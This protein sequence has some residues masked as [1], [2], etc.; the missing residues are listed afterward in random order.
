MTESPTQP[1]PQDQQSPVPAITLPKGGGAIRGIGEKF[2][3]NPVTG[4]GSITVPIASSPGRGG[5]GPQL[6]L[7]Y[8]S[9]SGN[10]P[11]GFGWSLGL[12]TITRK[13]DQG[14]P[15][16]HDGAESDVFLLSGAE[17]LVQVPGK[18]GKLDDCTTAPGY[19]IRRYRP[20]IEG[21]F[22]RVERWTSTTHREDV[23]WR[24][25]SRDNLLTLYGKDC[26]ARIYDP[27][28]PGRIFSW[29][30]CETRDTKGN[31]IIYCYKAEDGAQAELTSPP[32]RNRGGPKDPRRAVNRYI[33]WIRYA[34]RVPL[35]DAAG[36]R[37]RFLTEDQL[38]HA[39]WCFEVVFDYGEHDQDVPSRDEKKEQTWP[40]RLDPFSTY[41]PG[42]EVRT[43]RLCRRVLMFHHFPA[44]P[45]VGRDCLVRSTDFGYATSPVAS[46]LKSVTQRGYRR[47]V[48]DYI[49]GSM[50]AVEFGYS[51][52]IIDD[53]IHNVDAG[54]LENLPAGIDDAAYRL[55][56]LDSEGLEGVLTDAGG[57]WR[58]KPNLGG[59][60]LGP[61]RLTG[62]QPSTAALGGGQQLRDLAGDGRLDLV[63]FSGPT[64]GFF[65]R[66]DGTWDL[67]RPFRSLPQ[68]AW[69]D[70]RLRTVDLT[71]DGL[72]D[73]LLAED[74]VFTWY[75]SLG[76]DGF[77][78][79]RR[80]HQLRDEEQGPRLVDADGI[81][82]IY[83]ADMS[84]DG[85]NDL[86]RIRNGEV[87]Y[88]PSLGYGH[89]G[90]KITMA[91]A[92]VFDQPDQFS[93]RRLRVADIDGSG[94]TDL[95][96]LGQDG[97]RLYFNQ[98][99]NG[100]SNARRL[101]QFPPIDDLATVTTAD[102]LGNGTA[103]LI[104]SSPLPQHQG[105]Q[106]RYIDL[107]GGRKPHLL[108]KTSNN[109]GAETRVDY[110]P[111]TTF[112]LHDKA[113]GRPWVTRLPFPVHVVERV[114]TCDQIGRNRFVT[115]YAYHHGFF[116]G[117]EREFRGFAMV[118]QWDTET[119]AALSQ[120]DSFPVGDNIDADSHVPP[121]HTKTWFHTGVYLGRGNIS[122]FFAGL[123]D[124]QDPGEYY[125]EPAW[126][127]DDDAA[128]K[129]LLDDTILP[130]GLTLEEE[131][132]ACRALKGS[133]LR[134]EIYAEDGTDK[135]NH[136]Y[137]VT[138]Q[139]L[140]VRM[141][142]PHRD[143]NH[144]AVFFAHP[145]EAINYHYERNP[146]D[147]RILHT[148]TLEVDPFGNVLKEAAV[149]YGRP[150]T[151]ASLPLEAGG[152]KQI[153]PLITYTE[154]R[155][156]DPV[157][158]KDNHHMPLPA[159]TRTYELTGYA[160]TGI[161][162][163]AKDFVRP[164]PHN[165]A[166]LIH[167]F[168]QELKYEAQATK[169]RQ[170]RLIE[171]VRIL[172]RRNNLTG[173]LGLGELESLAL[174]GES[175]KLAFTAGLIKKVFRRPHDGRPHDRR[176]PED[177]IPN[178]AALLGSEGGYV[179]LDGD[180][181]WWI[182]RGRVFH[183]PNTTDTAPQELA[184]A[185]KHFFLT[186]RYRDPFGHR[187][188][189][190]FDSHDLLLLEARDPLGNRITVAERKPNGDIDPTKLGNDYRVLQPWFVMD[191][192]RN[193]TQVAFDALG[194]VVGVA[195]MGK[196]EENLGDSLA[197]FQAD[198]PEPV[199]LDH[200]ATPLQNPQAILQQAS[201]RLVYDLL[202]Y[203][204]T[205][206]QPNPR[207]A[208]AYTM[209]RETHYAE[210][211]GQ[212]SRVQHAFSYSDGFG[213]EI[214]KRIQAEPGPVPRRD[215]MGVIIFGADGQPEMTANDVNPR[216]VGSGWTIFN[217]KGK[218][219]RQYEPFFSEMHRFEFAL[220][221]GVSPVLFYDP[222]GRV[223]ATLHPNH[224]WEKAVFGPW[225]QEMWDVN[226]TVAL[227]A[228]QDDQMRP[229]LVRPDGSP[230][231]PPAD[232]TPSWLAVRTDPGYV[233]EA[234]RRWPDSG[235][236]AAEKRAGER[237]VVHAGTPTVAYMDVL[238][239]AF[240]TVSHNK[241]RYSDTGATDPPVEEF[242]STQVALDI[243]GN[244]G[245]VIDALGR[246]VVRHDYD[247]LGNLIHRAEMDSGERWMLD[248]VAGNALYRWD[249][250]DQRFRT[251]YDPLGR[252]TE[253]FLRIG[254]SAELLVMRQVYGEAKVNAEAANLRGQVVQLFDQAGIVTNDSY[255]FKGN[256]LSSRRQI[257]QAYKTTVDWSRT[258]P[259]EP[260]TFVNRTSYDALNRP[261]QLIAPHSDRPGSTINVVQLIHNE[262][263]LLDK[264]HAWLNQT[265]EPTDSLDPA[266]AD[267]HVVTDISYDARGRRIRV[268]YGTGVTT[269]YTYDSLSFR[270]VHLLT[271]RP[272]GAFPDDCPK[273]VLSGWPGC[274]IQNLHYAYDPIG[275]V[276]SIRDDAQQA[277][278]FRNK[279]VEP[280]GE[281]VYDALYRLIEA[282]GREH[283]G[284]AGSG[285]IPHTYNDARR[286]GLPAADA[287]GR[288]SPRDGK[289]MGTY[290][291]RYL[292]D[293]VGNLMEMR[294]RGSDPVHAGWS[295]TYTYAEISLIECG[296]G[297]DGSQS[298]IGNRL[299]YTSVAN[300]SIEPYEYDA[301]GNM[302]SMPQLQEM[303]WDYRDQLRMTR[304]QKVGGADFDGIQR[305][306]ERTYYV[307][308]AA[309]QRIRTVTERANGARKSERISL[310]GFDVFR[311][312]AGPRAGLVRETLH[313][314]ADAQRV[315]LIET[316][317]DV[318]DGGPKQLVRYQ[319]GNHLG[320]VSMELDDRARLI[321]YEEYAPYG[322][323]MFQAV[324]KQAETPKRFRYGGK[325][326]DPETG[327]YYHG[328]RFYAPWLGRWTS[329]DPA[330]TDGVSN[331]YGYGAS[332]PLRF[333]DPTGSS[334]QD[335]V[336][337][338]CGCSTS[339][340][341][342]FFNVRKSEFDLFPKSDAWR[343]AYERCDWGSAIR[344]SNAAKS[345]Q[346][347]IA[348]SP[349]ATKVVG[350]VLGV[351]SVV[352][353]NAPNSS[354]L[355]S[356]MQEYYAMFRF[357]STYA[358]AIVGGMGMLR[359][360]SSI[361]RPPGPP[362]APP[363][364][365]AV[366]SSGVGSS[367]VSGIAATNT[368]I[369]INLMSMMSGGNT[370]DE[371]DP[372]PLIDQEYPGASGP[373]SVDPLGE[374]FADP[375]TK[376]SSF[377]HPSQ[378]VGDHILS[379][380]IARFR[381]LNA[382][383]GK[384]LNVKTWEANA[385]KAGFEGNYLK[386]L[387]KYLRQ[388]L[389]DEEAVSVLKGELNYITKEVHAPPV[390][391]RTLHDLPS[392]RVSDSDLVCR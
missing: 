182:P 118:E 331:S 193:R 68:I 232:Y 111:S 258:V 28:D 281:Y 319:L 204:R 219:V 303:A 265:A 211:G 99:G 20:R 264:V 112:Y 167:A 88:W 287:V 230:R 273:P 153:S 180:G 184:Y 31:A 45:G 203:Q 245:D 275:N 198:L 36:Q 360:I 131:R 135:A 119:F 298:I 375:S 339:I 205:K 192:N 40:C 100:W 187:S 257:A 121:V 381:E 26:T 341:D 11:F 280:S 27:A 50:P 201:T 317:N 43:Y 218:P 382:S 157:A 312:Y 30:I 294:H 197:G 260:E 9:G 151:D 254:S 241:F 126:R 63:S 178:P 120:S 300:G 310:N 227:D 137:T 240:F 51:Q 134:Q 228:T 350:G 225:S 160:P 91:N 85:L 354:E 41:R 59:G 115:R 95:I 371:E 306:G 168:D 214:Q 19:A 377:V 291:E 380:A 78:E 57:A 24:S 282:D 256:L 388:G 338:F 307:Y 269:S 358:T 384:N 1:Q 301:H 235:T 315:A 79:A 272:A 146:T 243:E 140:T 105:R 239:R 326:R 117:V 261:I 15:Q 71:G 90:A 93:Q 356:A 285:P 148:L 246:V 318:D 66:T 366:E 22:A 296:A 32:E 136:P 383:S 109:L 359:S 249:S 289:A 159:E 390:D 177:L 355:P 2:A 313:V 23:H 208:V 143:G 323:T 58:Y 328:A 175:Y 276:I 128:R 253:F 268:D 392:Q 332:N 69:D 108:I 154:K 62:P 46:F 34:N 16:Y 295:R 162:L 152:A 61:L 288:F 233:A 238:G 87:C 321:S 179:E 33:K 352:H 202:A 365:F 156:T 284:Q 263:Y 349:V 84:G 89:F 110:A 362:M 56:D 149:A 190:S 165:P 267:L 283:L 237:S 302:L 164:D 274:Q 206:H 17:D 210:P 329:C 94:T 35:L 347:A 133:M 333:V 215:A 364:V 324:R 305:Q 144:H 216:W 346:K 373:R 196:P 14:L 278:Y 60:R 102:L 106:L 8:D 73:V 55:V 297:G 53:T 123:L 3:A 391:T 262:A 65:E 311:Q 141:L 116:D 145:C 223:V 247:M 77:A 86:V 80:V 314:M 242:H 42:F 252:P 226:D 361:P 155:V 172:Y 322:C 75:P 357:A 25:W 299:S 47:D 101:S 316:R 251:M 340:I 104:W 353:P 76:E 107:M 266:T 221:V 67:F 189:V 374:P 304:R 255:D 114:E 132:E 130:P 369:E 142:Q 171:H 336:A 200:L 387:I 292:Y 170:R 320:S 209:A 248:D 370:G 236:R 18:N 173:L 39:D 54:T 234:I 122:D 10:G 13:T 279:R 271:R 169:G 37:P 138:E 344:N 70:P 74:D 98:S 82:Q 224:T 194:L 290:V 186:H 335:A 158:D 367:A 29:L 345:T 348:S 12:P 129:R 191:A 52:A 113:A 343:R 250:R 342:T 293:A 378:P 72:A 4:T 207:P 385:R 195:V 183:S 96:Y 217:N 176:P 188:T 38:D 325:E 6:A 7:S 363:L 308:D 337:R 368:S 81:Q 97:A 330:G 351:A 139:N 181:R 389:T 48:S 220:R 259:R 229:F 372:V 64:P 174:L 150:H 49:C 83:L 386:D 124:T 309:G 244:H 286:V 327:L 166:R 163:Q 231:L 277:V 21:L 161:R 270:L 147:P 103:C 125:R 222:I 376:N 44:E 92:P 5:F 379:R 213:R 212:Q 185:R 127:D 199:V 334:D